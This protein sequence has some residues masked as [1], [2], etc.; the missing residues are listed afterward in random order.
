MQGPFPSDIQPVENEARDRIITGLV[1]LI[2]FVAIGIAAWQVA[3][4]DGGQGRERSIFMSDPRAGL[5]RRRRT[6]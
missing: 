3:G 6:A 1:T 5:S 4:A 2:P